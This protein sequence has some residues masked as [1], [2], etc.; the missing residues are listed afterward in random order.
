MD[1][2]AVI[3]ISILDFY[4]YTSFNLRIYKIKNESFIG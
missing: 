1:V 2:T 4:Q 3:I